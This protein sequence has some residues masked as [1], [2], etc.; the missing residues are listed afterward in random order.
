MYRVQNLAIILELNLK[1]KKSYS[2]RPKEVISN[3][4]IIMRINYNRTGDVFFTI[5]NTKN[6]YMFD[7]LNCTTDLYVCVQLDPDK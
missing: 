2:L 7:T 5:N 6:E 4:E 1:W 3:L